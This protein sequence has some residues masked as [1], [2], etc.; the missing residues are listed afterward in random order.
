MSAKW[1]AAGQQRSNVLCEVCEGGK[2]Y[3]TA[4]AT[5]WLASFDVL[6]GVY[7]PVIQRLEVSS[8]AAA[9]CVM[10][11]STSE[12]LAMSRRAKAHGREDQAQTTCSDATPL[13]AKYMP[14]G[15]NPHW[16]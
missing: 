10:L 8:H 14:P 7:L 11:F 1:F 13:A 5:H 9:R 4:F 6:R 15:L 2:T 3:V 12:T 16:H